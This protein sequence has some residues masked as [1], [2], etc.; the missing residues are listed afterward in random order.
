MIPRRFT[1]LLVTGM[2][3]LATAAEKPNIVLIMADDLGQECIGSYGGGTCKTPNIDQLA[4]QGLRFPN[5][6]SQP[7]CTPSR[8]QLMTG[9]YN[10][11]NYKMFGKLDPDQITFGNMLKD[12]GYHTGIVG[13]WQ[14]GGDDK[15]IAAFGFEAYNLWQLTEEKGSR[16]W[17]PKLM[18]DGQKV[19]T[20]KDDYGPDIQQ[21]WALNFISA[22]KNHP[23]FL[24]YPNV[25]PHAPFEA[26][27]DNPHV[28][29]KVETFVAMVSYLDKQVGEIAAHLRKEGLEKNTILMFIGDNG[30][31]QEIKNLFRGEL[32][33]GEKGLPSERG[34]HVPL[35][36]SWPGTIK[37]GVPK[38]LVDFTD[39]FAT[40]ANLAGAPRSK[41]ADGFSL[42]PAILGTGPTNRSWVYGWYFGADKGFPN[43][44]W[45]HDGHFWLEANGKTFDIKQSTAMTTPSTTAEAV[46]ATTRLTE[47]IQNMNARPLE[48]EKYKGKGKSGAED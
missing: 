43:G 7:L 44:E 38:D 11:R 25:L 13:K 9:Q 36:V 42:L 2:L 40:C 45:A 39:F 21:R 29:G 17:N 12:E 35:I 1:T 18:C 19:E 37:P 26:P 33:K 28:K 47:V 41:N 14:L 46:Q 22:N 8:V 24:Y 20:S 34:T 30:T 23:F 5:C 10:F 16:Y 4:E 3:T 32:Q 27:P 31:D 48:K 15:A 6:F